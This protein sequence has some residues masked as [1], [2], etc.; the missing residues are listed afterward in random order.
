MARRTLTDNTIENLK[1]K[2]TRYAVADPKLAGHYIRVTPSGSKSFAAVAR[3]PRGKQ[4]WHTIGSSE[5]Y[6]IEDARELARIAIKA[7]RAGEDRS[8]AQSFEAVAELWFKRHVEAKGLRSAAHIRL[9]PQQAYIARV[10]WSGVHHDPSRRCDR[11][12]GYRR[13]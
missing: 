12:T 9:L 2:A 5:L 3:D 4:V 8:G 13:G 1:P 6:K 7:I 10:G 11:A